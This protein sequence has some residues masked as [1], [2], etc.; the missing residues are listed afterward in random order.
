VLECFGGGSSPG[1]G[2]VSQVGL[3]KKVREGGTFAS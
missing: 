3:W 1:G 2:C